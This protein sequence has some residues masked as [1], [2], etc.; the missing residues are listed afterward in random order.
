MRKL[1]ILALSVALC[2]GVGCGSNGSKDDGGK[3][4]SKVGDPDGGSDDGAGTSNGGAGHGG[5]GSGAGGKGQAGD[6]GTSGASGS[7]AAGDGGSGD[8]GSGAAGKG[9]GG[10]GA[11]SAGSGST[12]KPLSELSDTL[13][14]AICDALHTCL[15]KS[16]LRALTEREDCATR[17]GA[18]LRATDF[19][20]LDQAVTDGRV[21]YDPTSLPDCLDDIR[22]LECDVLSHSLPK[23][24]AAV[25]GGNVPLDG[26]CVISAE[27]AGTAF[28]AGGDQCPTHCTALLD[29]GDA[30]SGDNECS[31]GLICAAGHCLLPSSDGE[32]C[33]GD[34]GKICRLGFTCQGSTDVDVGECVE[35]STVQVGD[36]NDACEPG[37]ALCK[38]GLSCVSSGGDAFHCEAAVGSGGDCHLG[39][40][41]QCPIDEYCDATDVTAQ[42][43][44][45]KLPGD[46][47]A[48]V[49]SGSCAAG[50]VCVSED[51]GST[52]RP[53]ADNC[54]ACSSDAA[55]RSQHCDQGKC[56]PPPACGEASGC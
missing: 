14:G 15:G 9:S 8:G 41:S 21:L 1:S 16:A 34:S 46:G 25:I 6:G 44:C 51:R 29:A 50:L 4:P 42:S 26:E 11:G 55:C 32:P 43:V 35:N 39:L 5:S 23:S 36:V 54:G 10:T 52:C 2:C 27:C 17:V 40:P 45:R 22:A 13:A 3:T 18:Q 33:N 28:C 47:D 19:A 56:M 30:C 38:E 31:D 48:C 53:I 24:C 7:G 12:S 37:G 49:L 20:Y